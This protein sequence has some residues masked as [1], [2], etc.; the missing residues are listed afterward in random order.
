MAN[1][2][3]E[4]KFRVPEAEKR[5]GENVAQGIGMDLNS[6]MK[7]MLRRFVAERGFPFSMKD[8]GLDM[9]PSKRHFGKSFDE[10]AEIAEQAS[11]DAARSHLEAGR[12]ITY[13]KDGI[14]VT[15]S[16]DGRVERA[17]QR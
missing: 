17:P 3:A 8:P 7:V 10:I 15:E 11:R 12:S 6:A 2:N 16:P 9:D 4:I 1:A 5:A 13:S 14:V